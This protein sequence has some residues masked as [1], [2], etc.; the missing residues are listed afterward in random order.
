MNGGLATSRGL[1]D[2]DYKNVPN[3]DQLKQFVSPEPDVY[4]SERSF[5]DN[6]LILACDGIWDVV[7]NEDLKSFVENKLLEGNKITETYLIKLSDDVLNICLNR[8][9]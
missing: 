3:I 5:D 4:I 1:G 7:A 9:N 2:F 6:F 8:V